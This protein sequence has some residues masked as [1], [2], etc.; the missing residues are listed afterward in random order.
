MLIYNEVSFTIGAMLEFIRTVVKSF[1]M[2]FEFIV[3]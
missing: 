3:T 2:F 1:Y